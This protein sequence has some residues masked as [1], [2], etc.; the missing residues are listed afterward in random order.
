M[1]KGFSPPPPPQVL[2][3]IGEVLIELCNENQVWHVLV[4]ILGN[5]RTPKNVKQLFLPRFW[6]D[7][8]HAAGILKYIGM[9]ILFWGTCGMHHRDINSMINN[10][11]TS[12]Q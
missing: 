5:Y 11:S 4:C 2:I 1:N 10:H 7:C 12:Y 3:E 6:L 8:V 9:S